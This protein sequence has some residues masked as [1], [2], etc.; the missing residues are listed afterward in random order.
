MSK[1]TIVILEDHPLMLKS[2]KDYFEG[3]GRWRVVG[4]ASNLEEAKT[5]LSVSAADG[6]PAD[7]L[8]LDIQLETG[9]GLDI[10]PWLRQQNGGG[11]KMPALAVYSAFSDYAHVSA[12]LGMGVRAYVTKN[13][14][15]TELEEALETA[16]RGGLYTDKT[17][18]R[19]IKAV[20]SALSLLTKREG[21]ILTLV[22]TGLSNKRIAEQL[23]ISRRTVENILS[24]VY[25]KTGISS[26]I[27]LQKL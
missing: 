2:L 9:W 10:I 14:N 18:E 21:E 22:K 15:E 3:T 25:D 11:G 23:G 1:A 27:E 17:V 13:R 16:L 19:E 5:L 26:R 20:T 24:C 6:N 4:A 7:V 12:A 8:L